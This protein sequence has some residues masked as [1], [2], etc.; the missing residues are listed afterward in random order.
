MTLNAALMYAGLRI[1]SPLLCVLSALATLKDQT[2]NVDQRECSVKD[3][4]VQPQPP[5]DTL[6]Q[7]SKHRRQRAKAVPKVK[8]K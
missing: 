3:K 8:G 7:G 1:N 6:A 4:A 5:K 2:E